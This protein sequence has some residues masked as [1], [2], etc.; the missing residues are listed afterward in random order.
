MT[1][2]PPAMT[3]ACV[4]PRT[5]DAASSSLGL[6]VC[7]PRGRVLAAN[8]RLKEIVLPDGGSWGRITD[9]CTLLGCG[10]SPGPLEGACLTERSLAAGEPLEGVRLRPGRGVTPVVV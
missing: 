7:D 9:C 8:S 6:M 10:R 1:A 4:V 2:A 5:S 3:T